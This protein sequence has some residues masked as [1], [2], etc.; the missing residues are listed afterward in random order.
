MSRIDAHHHV[1]RPAPSPSATHG[2]APSP[3]PG[4]R[5]RVH[6]WLDAP[7][8]APVRRDFTLEDLAPPGQA[9]GVD[10][11]I[12]VQVLPDTGETEDFL[13]LASTAGTVAGV[14][15]WVDLPSDRLPRTLDTLRAAPGGE[16]LVGTRHLVQ[17]ERDPRWLSR[18]DVRRGLRLVARADLAYDLLVRP[19]QLPAAIEAVR[20]LPELTFVLDHPAEPPVATGEMQPWTS[21]V[22]ELAALLNAFCKLSGMATEAGRNRWSVATLRPCA[23]V[24]LDAF[25]PER[26]MFGSDWPVCLPAAS[27]EEVVG[28]AEALTDGLTEAERSHV[29]RATAERAYRLEERHRRGRADDAEAVEAVR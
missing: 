12:L 14:V 6:A 13:T 19:H 3:G 1:R 26:V 15:R 29:F 5:R 16:L 25:G 8:T 21:L 24:V 28:A 7:G 18:P 23:D 9:A 27:H 2:P 22:R 4:P 10:R 17:D 11:T 20:E